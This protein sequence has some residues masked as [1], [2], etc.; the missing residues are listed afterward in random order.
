MQEKE[1]RGGLGEGGRGGIRTAE[2]GGYLT[3]Q[4]HARSSAFQ[5]RIYSTLRAATLRQK[6]QIKLAISLSHNILTSGQPIPALTLNHQAPG[7]VATR[8]PIY[9]QLV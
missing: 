6:L 4:Q 8:M 3:S 9:K 1:K 7:R 2:F 5:G